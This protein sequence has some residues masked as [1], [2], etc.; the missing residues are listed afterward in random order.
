MG[1]ARA[2]SG[3][4][5][6]LRAAVAAWLAACAAGDGPPAGGSARL[7]A[8]LAAVPDD[9]A[10]VRIRVAGAALAE[11]LFDASPGAGAI[12][13]I[14]RLEPGAATVRADAF[15]AS[16]ALLTSSSVP[17][18]IGGPVAVTL[19]A[20]AA[21]AIALPMRRDMPVPAIPTLTLAVQAGSPARLPADGA[22]TTV[23]V[24]GVADAAGAPLAGRSV[25][26]AIP[27]GGGTAA[28]PAVTGSD[29]SAAFTLTASTAAGTYSYTA[30]IAGAQSGAASLEFHAAASPA[31]CTLAV[32]PA[33]DV[34][35]NGIRTVQMVA[36]L[37]D[38]AGAPM[39]G[40]VPEVAVSG[41]GNTASPCTASDAAGV[42]TC[43]LQSTVAETKTVSFTSPALP[44]TATVTFLAP[45]RVDTTGGDGTF[46][47]AS[48]DATRTFSF[49]NRGPGVASSTRLAVTVTDWSAGGA[50]AYSV[51]EDTCNGVVLVSDATC[52]LRVTFK[53]GSGGLARGTYFAAWLKIAAHQTAD[54]N[55]TGSITFPLT[56]TTAAAPPP[57]PDAGGFGCPGGMAPGNPCWSNEACA[58]CVCAWGVCQ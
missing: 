30:S 18:W 27:S 38:Y 3:T 40:V 22:S 8:A 14:T 2:S 12:F 10:C 11:G 26:L 16:C 31:L 4:A 52:S 45:P 13:T 42:S 56:G 7:E 6:A 32:V 20:G 28:S 58:S 24:A 54:A 51:T 15:A 50:A 9:V 21:A 55:G 23:L 19:V 25:S 39:P 48:A 43:P 29:G 47:T 41:S 34:S 37:R 44:A 46:G 57:A 33:G 53:A 5:R 36:T 1:A 17:A 49:V 35:A